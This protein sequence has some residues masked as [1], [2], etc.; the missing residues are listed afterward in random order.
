VA[1]SSLAQRVASSCETRVEVHR[2]RTCWVEIDVAG[3]TLADLLTTLEQ[4]L[5][6]SDLQTLRVRLA[7]HTYLLERSSPRTVAH[8]C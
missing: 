6:Q 3:A 2:R 5:D 8:G 7:G 4:W 1:A